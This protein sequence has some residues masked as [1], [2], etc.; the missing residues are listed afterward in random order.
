MREEE[1]ERV[2]GW[3]TPQIAGPKVNMKEL[4]PKLEEGEHEKVRPK[5]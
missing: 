3:L 2:G 4:D 5:V 1:H